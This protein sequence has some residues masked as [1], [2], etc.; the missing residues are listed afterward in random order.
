MPATGPSR[1]LGGVTLASLLAVAVGG[2]LGTLSRYAVAELV[3]TTGDAFPWATF[4][5]NVTGSFALALLLTV[6]GPS[7][8]AEYARLAAGT[9]FMG[10]YTTFSTFAVENDQL[11]RHGAIGMALV[12]VAVTLV[13]G[14]G[15]ARLG[16]GVGQLLVER[17][18]ER[19][20]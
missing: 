8:R 12:Y 13:V 9:G 17:A 3:P 15:A 20:R 10:S 7:R 4:A 11:L 1:L 6:L 16:I 5:V 14:L 19:V 2:V 18:E